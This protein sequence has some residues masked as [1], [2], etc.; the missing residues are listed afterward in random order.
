MQLVLVLSGFLMQVCVSF[1]D[2][3]TLSLEHLSSELTYNASVQI[4]VCLHPFEEAFLIHTWVF[5]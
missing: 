3:S 5:T 4:V 2:E 1:L